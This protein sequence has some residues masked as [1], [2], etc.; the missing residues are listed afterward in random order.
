MDHS[1]TK[2]FDVIIIGAGP[3]GCTCALTLKDA[4]LRVALMDKSDF[5]RD[6][7]CGESLHVKGVNALRSIGPDIAKAFND[8]NGKNQMKQSVIHYRKKK[9]VFDWVTESFVVRRLDFDAFML[10][11]VKR[12]TSTVI[13]TG[14]QIERIQV[15][16]GGV[17]V[18]I[19]NEAEPYTA[20]MVIGADG[21]NS[22]VA[23]QL[24]S[25]VIDR[26]H[27]FGAVRAYY[28]NVDIASDT[29]QVFFNTRYEFNYLWMFPINNEITNVGFGMLSSDISKN[30]VNLKDVFYEF[31]KGTPEIADKLRN[32]EQV[33]P[34]EGFGV[35]LGTNYGTISGDRFMLTGDAASLSNPVS[36]TGMGNA[37]VSGK[38]AGDQVIQCFKNGDFTAGFIKQYEAGVK[39]EIIDALMK[40]FKSHNSVAR[41]PF[42]LDIVFTLGQF[43]IFRKKIQSMV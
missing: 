30:K 12:F 10:S 41:L 26:K 6:K 23:K 25:R 3:A 16:D 38:L 37:M 43:R 13:Y 20:K 19:K 39:T 42:I 17:T 2:D 18:N 15:T 4:G 14:V 33:G 24:T 36:G 29:T 21:A 22:I 35:P 40:T 32:A 27:Y 8:Y 7:T 1:S 34:L 28:K 5:P 31:I 11:L 9:L